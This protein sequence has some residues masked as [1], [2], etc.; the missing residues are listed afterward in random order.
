MLQLL[1]GGG[2][3]YSKFSAGLK[4]TKGSCSAVGWE[5]PAQVS[6]GLNRDTRAAIGAPSH[7]EIW[8][9][10]LD[11]CNCSTSDKLAQTHSLSSLHGNP[12]A[13]FAAPVIDVPRLTLVTP[14]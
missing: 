7:Q 12:D 2:K 8:I 13:E 5:G 11:Q 14:W 9:R 1:H 10:T 4:V 3:T 6:L